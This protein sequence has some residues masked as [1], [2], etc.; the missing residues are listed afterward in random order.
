MASS[1]PD[2]LNT[3][4]AITHGK[5]GFRSLGDA[6]ADIT[7]GHRRGRLM[8]TVLGV[9]AITIPDVGDSR[10]PSQAIIW[11]ELFQY[12][13][14]CRPPRAAATQAMNAPTSIDKA[15]KIERIRP[16]L[17]S[18]VRGLARLHLGSLFLCDHVVDPLLRIGLRESGAGRNELR[19]IG[20]VGRGKIAFR[21]P[22]SKIRVLCARTSPSAAFALG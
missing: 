10:R 12:S 21:M 13:S 2:L 16:R 18:R 1:P 7:K 20:L 22:L 4:A 19:E 14:R 8:L 3:L 11:A 15:V 6:W 5:A 17:A 9:P